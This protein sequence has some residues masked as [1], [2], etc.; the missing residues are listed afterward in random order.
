MSD[1]E[2]VKWT[3][4]LKLWMKLHPDEDPFAQVHCKYCVNHEYCS[5]IWEQSEALPNLLSWNGD[6]KTMSLGWHQH[7]RCVEWIKYV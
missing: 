5:E 1:K 4:K 7:W 6:S 2:I 3:N